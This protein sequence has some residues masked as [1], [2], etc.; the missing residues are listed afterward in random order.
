MFESITRYV[1]AFENWEDVRQPGRVIAE[2]LSDLERVANHDYAD[3]LARYGL[4]WSAESMSGADLTNAPAELAVALLTAAYRA[5]HFC[6]D[7]L[8]R[9]FIP[10]GLVSHCLRRLLEL[11]HQSQDHDE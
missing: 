2:F 9:E 8:E 3:T 5:D 4:E 1:E 11:D 7:I 10:N 6:N